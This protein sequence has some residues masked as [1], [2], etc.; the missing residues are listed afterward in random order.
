[1]AVEG[2]APLYGE[3]TRVTKDNYELNGHEFSAGFFCSLYNPV[4]P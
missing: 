3:A 4:T 2:L 1:M